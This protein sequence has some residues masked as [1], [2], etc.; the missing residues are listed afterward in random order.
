MTP[1]KFIG[2]Q[3][4]EYKIIEI[5]GQGGMAAVFKAEH[6]KLKVVRALKVIRELFS[7]D[8]KFIDRF[9]REARL[10]VHLKHPNLVHINEFF[11]ED[12]YL[13]L[14]MDYVPGESLATRLKQRGRLPEAEILPVICHVLDGLAEAHRNGIVHRDISPD[15]IM[16]SPMQN[17]T[18]RAVIID[19]GIAKAIL[20]EDFSKT[21]LSGLTG[22]GSFVGKMMYCSPEQAGG[23]AVDGRTDIYSL[24][25]VLHKALTGAIPFRADTPVDSMA[26]RRLQSI[27]ALKE[28]MP[29]GNFPEELEILVAGAC[30]RKPD[31]RFPTAESFK[32]AILDYQNRG[33]KIQ[34]DDSELTEIVQSG[35]ESKYPLSSP[36]EPKSGMSIWERGKAASRPATPPKTNIR[37]RKKPFLVS[38]LIIIAAGIVIVFGVF[39]YYEGYFSFESEKPGGTIAGNPSPSPAISS[40]AAPALI[41]MVRIS[42]GTFTRGSPAG[43]PGRDSDE[44]QNQVA[45]TRPFFIGIAEVTQSQYDLVM[46]SN[47]SHFKG[48]LHPVEE[49]TWYDA[50]DFC[51]RL[52]LKEGLTPCYDN[53]QNSVTWNKSALGYR[54]PTE[55]EWEYACRAGGADAFAFGSCLSASDADYDG[56]IPLPGCPN[57][58]DRKGTWDVK[59]GKPNAWGLC[60]MHGNVFEWCWD[61][62]G[63]YPGL[64]A[65]DPAGPDSGSDRVIRGGAWADDAKLCRSANRNWLTPDLRSS[66]LGFRV[67]RTVQR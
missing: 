13:F 30:A 35:I 11:E 62:Y 38:V 18:E 12:G 44:T 64:R 25:L 26:M 57:G 52:S 32:T 29:D 33:K 31:N 2:R 49:V 47:P 23:E 34:D 28:I 65:T 3:I 56:T 60:D 1:E 61:W 4:R 59:S 63:D 42:P 39:L 66:H 22:L 21:L 17:G 36:I 9:E 50:I 43:E 41:P 20:A 67:A 15:N 8:K 19:F 48:S 46:S 5:I 6:V 37:V 27:P 45:I 40:A 10:L 24:G 16:L 51:N 55:A 58:Q 54:L 14:V 53:S 7:K